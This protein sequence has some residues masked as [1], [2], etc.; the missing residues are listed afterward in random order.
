MSW[1]RRRFDQP[2]AGYHTSGLRPGLIHTLFMPL[3]SLFTKSFAV[4]LAQ[5]LFR[6][7]QIPHILSQQAAEVRGSLVG[8]GHGAGGGIAS[9][10]LTAE[11]SLR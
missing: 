2:G 10:Q 4:T 11:R 8:R 3:L 1:G 5:D 6:V 9:E 7:L